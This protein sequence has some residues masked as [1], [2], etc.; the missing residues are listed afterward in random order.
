MEVPA[1]LQPVL[2][3][4]PEPAT[5]LRQQLTGP[6]RPWLVRYG[7]QQAILR[8]S[9]PRRFKRST[10]SPDLALASIEWLHDFLRDLAATGTVAPAPAADLGGGSIAVIDGVIWELLTF[11]PGAPIGWTDAEMIEAGRALARFHEASAA[12][13]GRAQRPGSARMQESRPEHPDA[14]PVA[15]YV[16]TALAAAAEPPPL[17]I[18]GDATQ[19]N[20]VVDAGTFHL[21]DFALAY[22]EAP[23]GD[24]GSALWRN[25]RSEPDSIGYEPRR[26]ALFVRGYASVR[27]QPAAAGHAIVTY[28]LARGLQL[29]H[30]L[31]LRGA[32]DPTIPQRLRAIYRL[33]DALEEA[34]TTAIAAG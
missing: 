14:G 28:M 30:R 27:P 21:V 17:V 34:A 2:A 19:A 23:L 24:V 25:A 32:D 29:Q 5:D 22:R 3:L 20:M 1:E 8:S 15:A 11:V 13:P 10:F 33:K 12:V 16:E 26:V 6:G 18:H 7:P 9:D 31:E 4:L